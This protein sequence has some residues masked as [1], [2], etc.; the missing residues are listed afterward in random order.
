MSLNLVKS[1]MELSHHNGQ[2]INRLEIFSSTKTTLISCLH[3]LYILSYAFLCEAVLSFCFLKIPNRV[4]IFKPLLKKYSVD[5][6]HGKIL[7][8]ISYVKSFLK[9]KIIFT[10][11]RMYNLI[12]SGSTWL[13][14]CKIIFGYSTKS[15]IH[16]G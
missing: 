13:P 9:N 14:Y 12:S 16:K 7:N 4:E 2:F 11:P 10:Y 6:S 3:L 8:L 1:T 5:S 15:A